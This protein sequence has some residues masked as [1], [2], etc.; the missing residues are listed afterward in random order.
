MKQLPKKTNILIISW[1]TLMGVFL[2]YSIFRKIQFTNSAIFIVGLLTIVVYLF[3]TFFVFK[4]KT[5]QRI[6][7]LHL[8][9]ILL[10]IFI[11]LIAL[12]LIYISPLLSVILVI[13]GAI[14]GIILITIAVAK[15][16]TYLRNFLKRK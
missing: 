15:Y 1:L 9:G 7:V 4:E 3:I 14:V 13:I 16:A 11:Y 2:Y 5:I 10:P 6:R 8:I 12:A